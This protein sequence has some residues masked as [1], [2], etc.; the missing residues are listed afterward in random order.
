MEERQRGVD[1]I[2]GRQCGDPGDV[3]AGA[4]EA[5][6]G[7]AHGLWQTG[8][9]R[10]EDEQEQVLGRH[11]GV[12]DGFRLRRQLVGIYGVVDQHDAVGGHARVDPGEHRRVPTVGHDQLAV[13]VAHEQAELVT[14]VGRVMPTTTAPSQN[15]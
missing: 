5:P 2:A 14:P 3:G 12:G 6:L 13:G 10:G 7:A 11:R 9:A 1:R 8:R 4:D 15:R